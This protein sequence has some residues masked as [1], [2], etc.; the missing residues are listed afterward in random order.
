ML[1]STHKII[2]L[3]PPGLDRWRHMVTEKENAPQPRSDM[4]NSQNVN[5]K[6][7]SE[8]VNMA[9]FISNHLNCTDTLP[10]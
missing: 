2:C 3:L 9:Y 6:K 4:Q 10:R 7:A 8:S 1:R 5:R